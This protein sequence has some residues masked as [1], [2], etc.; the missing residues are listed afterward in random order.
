MVSGDAVL[1]S[2]KGTALTASTDLLVA[3]GQYTRSR[4]RLIHQ[5]GHRK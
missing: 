3:F 1:F 2:D 4:Q 5:D